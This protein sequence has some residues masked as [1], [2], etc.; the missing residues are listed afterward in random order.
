MQ[1]NAIIAQIEMKSAQNAGGNL[2]RNV[3]NR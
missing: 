3:E 1:N 2:V